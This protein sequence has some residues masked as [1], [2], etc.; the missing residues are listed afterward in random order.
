MGSEPSRKGQAQ[1]WTNGD[2]DPEGNGV[3]MIHYNNSPSIIPDQ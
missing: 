2:I 3:S 1:Y